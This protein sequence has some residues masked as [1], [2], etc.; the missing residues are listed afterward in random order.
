VRGAV[1][2]GRD[3][4]KAPKAFWKVSCSAVAVLAW[5]WH[6]SETNTAH[7]QAI[8]WLHLVS[9]QGF[10]SKGSTA[11]QVLYVPAS[12]DMHCSYML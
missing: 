2:E 10:N 12:V 3:W 8:G 7:N 6:R 5:Q 4:V 9:S 1:E 11:L